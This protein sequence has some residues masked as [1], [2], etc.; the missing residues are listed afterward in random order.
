M[1]DQELP[2]AVFRAWRESYGARRG[3]FERPVR[4]AAVWACF[5]AASVLIRVG[6]RLV[7]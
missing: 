4:T 1:R 2:D 3:W 6:V 5:K 7:G